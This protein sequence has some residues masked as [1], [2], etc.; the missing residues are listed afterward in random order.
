MGANTDDEFAP[1][2]YLRF[3]EEA[4]EIF[5][6]WLTKH[7]RRLLSDELEPALKSHFNKYR[8]LVASLSL[9]NHLADRGVGPISATALIRALAMVAYLETHA[10]RAYT[11]GTGV[12]ATASAILRR[13]KSGAISNEFTARAIYNR[14]WN[15]LTDCDQVQAGLDM[16]EAYNWIKTEKRDTGGR[17]SAVYHIHPKARS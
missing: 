1:I 17:P 12:A 8:K 6:D 11:A 14:D 16:L 9:V 2:P 5:S 15:G 4:Q 3:S 7:S 13:I 10:V